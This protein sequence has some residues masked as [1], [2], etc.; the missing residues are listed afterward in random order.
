[1]GDTEIHH[2]R[3]RACRIHKVSRQVDVPTMMTPTFNDLLCFYFMCCTEK[4]SSLIDRPVVCLF[5]TRVAGTCVKVVSWWF[6][7]KFPPTTR[8]V[9]FSY[10]VIIKSMTHTQVA[11]VFST[12]FQNCCLFICSFVGLFAAE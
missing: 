11:S 5:D 6:S 1:M 9:S 12:V 4:V 2:Q 3:H 10:L 8:G 7:L